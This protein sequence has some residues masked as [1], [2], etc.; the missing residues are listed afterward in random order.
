[1][2]S[3]NMLL[4]DDDPAFLELL[5]GLL[6]R[7]GISRFTRSHSG[8][9]AYRA[10][11]TSDG[12]INC[13]LCDIAMEDGSGLDFLRVVRAGKNSAVPADIPVVLVTGVEDDRARDTAR[14]LGASGFLLKPITE[15]RL[16]DAIHPR[17]MRDV[18]QPIR[19]FLER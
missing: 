1:M 9:D 19:G 18:F 13:V 17:R 5:E 7:F 12:Q 15:E 8:K 6:K 16:R 14:Q 10:L 2:N 3:L 11:A 4:V